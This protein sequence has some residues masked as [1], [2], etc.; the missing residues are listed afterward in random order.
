[1]SNKSPK[2]Q[3]A[4]DILQQQ[5]HESENKTELDFWAAYSQLIMESLELRDAK[6][7]TQAELAEKMRTKQSVVSRFE[8]MGRLPSYKFI[9]ELAQALGHVPGMTLY[10]DYMGV[11]PLQKQHLV[12]RLATQK[13]K[14][15]QEYVQF[16]LEDSLKF[17]SLSGS[18]SERDT[19][20]SEIKQ[21]L[22]KEE[23]KRQRAI[24][25]SA[26]DASTCIH[27]PPVASAV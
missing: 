14:T 9:V 2:A 4:I 8:N 25:R 24:T 13:G 7:V 23:D 20:A 11:I 3:S 15:T 6:R 1:M 10:G 18:Q 27:L 26:N 16:L 21:S 12:N 17:M 22:R 19:T 5:Y